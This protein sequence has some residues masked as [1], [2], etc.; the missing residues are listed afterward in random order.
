MKIH[1]NGKSGVF[2]FKRLLFLLMGLFLSINMFAQQ[3]ALTGTVVDETGSALVGVTVVVKGTT[4]GTLTNIDGVYSLSKVPENATLTFSFVGMGTQEIA[5]AGKSTVNVTMKTMAHDI[6]ELVVVG[7]GTQKKSLVTGSIAKVDGGD[8]QRTAA[9][10]VNQALQGKTAGV[11]IT[12]SSGQ[13]GDFVSIRVRGVGTNGNNEP[14]YI[15]DGLPTNGY[16]IDYL[17]SSDIESVEVLKDAAS[18]AIYGSRGGNGVVLITTK[19]G[20]KS[21]KF[22]VSYDGYYGFQNPWH[23]LDVLNASEYMSAINEAWTN[24]GVKPEKLLFKS[25]DGVMM[26]DTIKCKWDTDWQNEMINH[27]AMKENHVINL[28]GGSATSTYASSLSYFKQEGIVAKGQSS[29]ER[30]TYHLNTTRQFGLMTVGSNI[31]L[32][33][34]TTKS[35]G[36]NDTYDGSALVQALNMPPVVP[37]KF[38]NGTWATPTVFGLGMQEISNPIA[39]LSYRNSQTV[40]RKAVANVYADFDF[41]YMIKELSGLRFKTSYNY[42]YSNVHY[43]NYSPIYNLDP[44]HK[45]T[46]NSVTTTDNHYTTWN[47]DNTLTYVKTLGDN[48]F[49]ILLGH[50]AYRSYHESLTG[51]KSDVI[52]DDFEHAYLDNATDPTSAITGGTFDDHTIL[53]YFGRIDYDYNGKYMMTATVRRD[54][55]SRFGSANKYGYFPS[56]SAGWVVSRENFFAQ[57]DVVN[58]LKLRGSWGQNGNENI[59]NFGYISTMNNL[60]QIYYFGV[61]Q[62]QVNGMQPSQIA[63]PSLHWEKAE[64]ADFAIDLGLFNNKLTATLDFYSKTTKDWLLTA[65]V[66]YLVGN[67]APTVNGGKLNNKGI[68]LELGYKVKAGG[69]NIDMKL[70][71]AYNKNKVLD[72][73]NT[74]KVLSGGSGGFGQGGIVRF[75]VGQPAAFFWGYKTAGIFQNTDAVKNHVTIDSSGNSHILQSTAKPGD[76]IF[77]DTNKDGILTDLDRVNL[78]NAMPDFTGGFNLSLEW[79]GIDFNMFWYAAV[80]QESWMCLR[81]Y[82]QPAT[83]YTHLIYDNR[84]TGEGTSNKYPRLTK[85]DANFNGNWKTPSDLFIYDSSYGRLRSLTIGYTF[86]KTLTEKVK[87]EALRIYAMGENLITLTNYPGY[88]PEIGSNTTDNAFSSGVDR[89]VYPQPRTITFGLNI[90]F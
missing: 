22:N 88:D 83:N 25:V 65:P 82:D 58:F 26:R 72:I 31:N 24:S 47:I 68:E 49:T 10:R 12:N 61:D 71:G 52:F 14:L 32:A 41:G 64:Q 78:G 63:N 75:E 77:E 69:V 46:V 37:V 5:R 18:A 80:G 79:K 86:P 23:T 4:N 15:V 56:L 16:G 13:P 87:I 27:N 40:T 51:T 73:P 19:K 33:N 20:K 3:S 44:T 35:V 30:F 1:E 28:T 62:T 29:F 70:T 90:T 57:S 85:T 66:Q 21:E 17:N 55:S 50:S 7:Y 34:I 43:R 59:G 60:N 11:V 36:A 74:E 9:L 45:S 76:V 53:S 38:D 2:K 54:G 67:S 84:W 48:N 42:E 8:L 39:L 89:G 81:R 6:D